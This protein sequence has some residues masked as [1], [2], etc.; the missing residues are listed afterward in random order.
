MGGLPPSRLRRDT[1]LREGGYRVSANPRPP[2]G[3]AAEPSAA[4]GRYSE[5]KLA[6]RS[7][8]HKGA[9]SPAGKIG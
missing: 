8:F 5:A 7:N 9:P 2:Q 3:G 6:Q 4:C 1:S